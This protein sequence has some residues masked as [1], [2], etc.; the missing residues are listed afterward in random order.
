MKRLTFFAAGAGYVSGEA[1]NREA[2]NGR[3][4]DRPS[5]ARARSAERMPALGA[6]AGCISEGCVLEDRLPALEWAAQ[7][8]FCRV[9]PTTN[10][11]ATA[12]GRNPGA[13]WAA[14]IAETES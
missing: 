3:L 11:H 12:Q 7:D 10:D 2:L 8:Q 14:S 4:P 13:A 5:S 1:G 9:L 6:I